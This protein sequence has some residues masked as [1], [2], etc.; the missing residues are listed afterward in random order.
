MFLI[1]GPCQIESRDHTLFM[2]EQ[3]VAIT[4]RLNLPFVFKASYDK[5]NRTRHDSP[6]GV[7]VDEGGDILA[8]VSKFGC[9]TITDFHWPAQAMFM[10]KAVDI[11]QIPA[12]LSRQTDLIQ[13]CAKHFKTI[14]IK[15]GQFM[16]PDDVQHAVAKA[17][18]ANPNCEV[19]VTERGT[20]FG[21]HN[22]VVDFRSLVEMRSS[23]ADKIVFDA[24]H[25]VQYPSGE[26]TGTSG[27]DR[28]FVEALARAALAVGVDGLFI[29]THDDPQNA[30][31]DGPCMVPLH[32][33]EDLLK[34]LMEFDAL[35][36]RHSHHH[37][38]PPAIQEAPQ[39]AADPAGW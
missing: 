37:P 9:R 33:L 23:G 25:S 24:T 22:L 7:G 2:A 34:R 19:W 39:Q 18:A 30:L 15:K 27:G 29:E 5:A 17:K 28:V 20:T 32:Q 3:L 16:A 35:S 26:G 38:G 1:A 11:A 10:D 4:D 8:E 36:N 12:L 6:R 14:N 21:Y 31:S 13:T